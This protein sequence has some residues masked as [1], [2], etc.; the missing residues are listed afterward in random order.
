MLRRQLLRLWLGLVRRWSLD[1]L[2][3]APEPTST[4]ASLAAS[5]PTWPS[6]APSIAASSALSAAAAE[7]G[8]PL[9]R[10]RL[11]NL[12]LLRGRRSLHVLACQA[13]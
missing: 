3:A 13:E 5:E 10:S 8:A 12:L 2:S 1:L 6:A 7:Q 11:R 9:R 4:A